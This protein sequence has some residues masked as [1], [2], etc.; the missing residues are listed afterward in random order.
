MTGSVVDTFYKTN[1]DSEW[2]RPVDFGNV[3]ELLRS[4]RNA[5]AA[6]LDTQK[7]SQ[8][9]YLKEAKAAEREAER[10]QKRLDELNKAIA[11]LSAAAGMTD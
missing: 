7:E 9:H 3:L 1:P 10:A 11:I 5:V 2:P 6:R 4:N 8:Q